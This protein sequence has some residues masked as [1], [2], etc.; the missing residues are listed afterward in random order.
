LVPLEI[1]RMSAMPMMPMG[2]GEGREQR[3]AL[4][5]AQVVG[6]ELERGEEPQPHVLGTGLL[7]HGELGGRDGVGVR[8]DLAVLQADDAGGVLVGKLGVVRDHDH[9]AVGGDLLQQ[10][11]DLDAGLGVEGTGGLVGQ[12]DGR[13]VH[14]GAR[15]GHALHLAAAHHARLLVDLVAQPHALERRHRA[16][17]AVLLGAARDL[18]REL[19]VGEDALVH[20]E[21]VALE[22]E[23]HGAVAVGIPVGRLVLLGGAAVDHE[24]ARGVRVEATHDVEQG[25][26]A[27]AGLAQDGDELV[28]TEVDRDAAQGMDRLASGGRVFLG[29]VLE[30]QHLGSGSVWVRRH[31]NASRLLLVWL[32]QS[33]REGPA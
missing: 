17:T 21:V 19:H 15:D 22:H 20:D 2:A 6:R 16:G 13:V 33:T 9:E 7:A 12:D 23:P 18:E 24:V 10:V 1:E 14:E 32:Q 3:A 28:V 4:L 8:D 30:L 25:G 11:H 29:D 26:L 5:G 27:A 31:G